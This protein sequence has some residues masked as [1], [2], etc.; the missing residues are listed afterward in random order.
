[1]DQMK[2]LQVIYSCEV[3]S[4][5]AIVRRGRKLGAFVKYEMDRASLIIATIFLVEPRTSRRLDWNNRKCD[6]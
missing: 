4:S 6:G 2:K 5:A 3:S 1:M